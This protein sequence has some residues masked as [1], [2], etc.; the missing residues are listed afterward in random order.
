M[1]SRNLLEE[2]Q[3]SKLFHSNCLPWPE[4]QVTKVQVDSN[5]LQHAFMYGCLVSMDVMCVRTD[6]LHTDL[7]QAIWLQRTRG[8]PPVIFIRD[9]H[10]K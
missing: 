6:V 2:C 3:Q 10:D 8:A 9:Q 4:T 5:V 1:L 7:M